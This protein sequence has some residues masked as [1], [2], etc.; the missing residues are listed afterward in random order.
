[1][2]NKNIGSIDAVLRTDIAF[3][4]AYCY[5]THSDPT[6]WYTLG[7]ILAGHLL[8]TAV[9]GTSPI[10]K[11]LKISTNKGVAKCGVCKGSKNCAC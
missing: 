10:Y 3:V 6:M 8:A 1:M 5:Y 4:L 11:L 2:N 7:L 9:F